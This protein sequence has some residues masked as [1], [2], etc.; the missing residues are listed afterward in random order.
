MANY[1]NRQA[2][3]DR[4]AKKRAEQNMVKPTAQPSPGVGTPPTVAQTPTTNVPVGSNMSTITKAMQPTPTNTVQNFSNTVQNMGTVS[5][6]PQ[7]AQYNNYL[8][9]SNQVSKTQSTIDTTAYRNQINKTLQ[10]LKNKINEQQKQRPINVGNQIADTT[11]QYGVLEQR[12]LQNQIRQGIDPNSNLGQ[13]QRQNLIKTIAEQNSTTR[14]NDMMLGQQLDTQ[15]NQAQYEADTNIANKQ[16]EARLTYETNRIKNEILAIERDDRLTQQEKQNA[17]ANKN[18]EL[19]Q[20]QYDFEQTKYADAKAINDAMLPYNL[21]G[22]DLANQLT[23][24][25]IY[26]LKNPIEKISSTEAKS[27]EATNFANSIGIPPQ[28][29]PAYE[30][31]SQSVDNMILAISENP[32]SMKTPEART[33]AYNKVVATINS[34]PL[35]GTDW[36]NKKMEYAKAVLNPST[37]ATQPTQPPE[38]Q[39]LPNLLPGIRSAWGKFQDNALQNSLD[40]F[41]NKK[42]ETIKKKVESNTNTAL[43]VLKSYADPST[44]TESEFKKAYDD[45]IKAG[46]DKS[47][48]K[49]YKEEYETK[50]NKRLNF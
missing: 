27:Q 42:T 6:S 19:Q 7:P 11:K 36:A 21:R 3:L 37:G 5:T 24:A 28:L 2:I 14:Q 15:L 35:A 22:A 4:L 40:Y 33:Q 13:I 31:T 48:A 8:N 10:D 17:I 38:V 16:E 45:Y 23:E 47:I 9:S 50:R 39:T 1:T 44:A 20:K 46:G 26:N 32:D 49:K 43:D 18:M 25:Q 12:L 30:Q 29:L 34:S 41:K